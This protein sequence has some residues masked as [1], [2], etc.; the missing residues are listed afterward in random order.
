M[1]DRAHSRGGRG[2]G[3]RGDHRGGR[4]GG[5]DHRGGARGG[6]SGGAGNTTQERPK[7]ENILNLAKYMDKQI[8]VKFTGGREGMF[9]VSASIH[10]QTTDLL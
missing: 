4:G 8:N 10:R 5:G 9:I 7:K 1:A 6:G 3:G 2:A